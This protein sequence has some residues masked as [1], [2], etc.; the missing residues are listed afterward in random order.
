MIANMEQHTPHFDLYSVAW[1]DGEW[2]VL[3][4]FK[5]LS[6]LSAQIVA[7][8]EQIDFCQSIEYTGWLGTR[9]DWCGYKPIVTVPRGGVLDVDQ[10]EF[11]LESI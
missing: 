5:N 10:V 1:I 9:P 8:V 11:I 2:H 7:G 3:Q 6:W 4:I